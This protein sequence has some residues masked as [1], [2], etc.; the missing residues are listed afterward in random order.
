MSNPSTAVI[1]LNW[2]GEKL[3]KEFL[4]SVIAHTPSET[5]RVIVA[6]NGS[7]D[8]SVEW[9]RESCPGVELIVF[10]KNYGFAE[11]YNRAIEAVKDRYKYAVLLN[12]DVAVKDDWL[13]PLTR[14]LDSNPDIAACQPKLL[15]YREPQLFEYAGASGGF[16]DRHGYPFC[17]GRIFATCEADT[18]QY[19]TPLTV[20]WASGAALAVRIDIYLKAGGLDSSFFAHMEEIDLCWRIRRM[21]MK[22]AVVPESRVY[23]LGGGSLPPSNPR[24]TYLNYRNNL[25]MLHKN[26]PSEVR[27]R[28]IF[29]RM[30]LDG[31]AWAKEVAT[32]KWGN[33]SA[34]IRAHNDFRKM[35]KAASQSGNLSHSADMAAQCYEEMKSRPDIIRGYFME[36]KRKFSDY[37]LFFGRGE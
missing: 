8:S 34:I 24:K 23:H 3:L 37:S 20:D 19:D 2:N 11:G 26:L 35:K 10:P 28:V 22:I 36:G 15:S 7:T 33:A 13:T 29:K 32:M 4:P 25:L 1:I 21:G 14:C 16:I 31:V 30:I 5:G 17:R 6:D 12:S 27:D 9:L 18:G